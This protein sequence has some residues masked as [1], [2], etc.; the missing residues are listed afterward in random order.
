MFLAQSRSDPGE[1]LLITTL[2]GIPL[3]E[4]DG[5][6]PIAGAH[7]GASRQRSTEEFDG[8]L[9]IQL[10]GDRR[11]KHLCFRLVGLHHQQFK[12][13]LEPSDRPREHRNTPVKQLSKI[14]SAEILLPGI[15]KE[16]ESLSLSDLMPTRFPFGLE[17][18][19]MTYS[20]LSRQW[21]RTGTRTPPLFDSYPDSD[22][23]FDLDSDSPDCQGLTILAT[24]QSRIIFWK[25][26]ESADDV[27]H[28]RLV[29][30]LRDLPYQPGRPLSPVREEEISDTALV[31]YSTTHSTP[32][33]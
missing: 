24:P 2:L 14:T 20:A 12:R 5:K 33:R 31:D 17:N 21:D 10:P 11:R 18:S 32:D 8:I 16:I 29:A 15:A 19:A 22:D 7:R 3:G 26:S 27:N 25:D 6:T 13:F 28:A 9:R 1:S 23:D 4:P 30:C